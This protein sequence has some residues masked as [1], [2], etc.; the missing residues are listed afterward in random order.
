MNDEPSSERDRIIDDLVGYLVLTV[1]D[2]A[3]LGMV[4][5]ALANLVDAGAIR[6]LDLA[7]VVRG[8]DGLVTILELESIESLHGLGDVDGE[9]GRLLTEQDLDQVAGALDPGR[10]G[11][12]IVTEDR[13]AEPLSSAA[14]QVGGAILAGERI[15]SARL[16]AA[17]LERGASE[18][19]ELT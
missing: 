13:W 16:R 12:I 9:Y 14:H 8:D 15:P 2:R 19:T 1:P 10:T 3:G 17:L 7:V 5:P 11:F 6:I 18:G 4:V